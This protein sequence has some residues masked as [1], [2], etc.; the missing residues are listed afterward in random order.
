MFQHSFMKDNF[1]MVDDLSLLRVLAAVRDLGTVTEAGAVL[2][3]S[4]SAVSQQLKRLGRR[5]E[6]PVTVRSGRRVTLTPIAHD[7]LERATPLLDQLEEVLRNLPP[8]SG[9]I[10]GK[11]RVAA[12]TTAIR[13]GVPSALAHLR[14][15]HPRLAFEL[16]EL[17]PDDAYRAVASGRV[18]LAVVHHWEG[19]EP[20]THS[21]ITTR[22]VGRDVAD[23]IARKDDFP[24][25]LGSQPLE[26]LS[27]HDWVSTGRGTLC[28]SWLVS[29]FAEAGRAPQITAQLSDFTLHLDFVRAGLGLALIPRLGR[30][31]LPEDLAVLKLAHPPARM[32]AI[33]TRHVQRHDRAIEATSDQLHTVLNDHQE[34]LSHR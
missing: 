21:S 27:A 29:M 19:Q 28:H 11:V 15:L 13:A 10:S 17:D 20:L 32:V 16:I 4:P 12:F 22:R 1:I 5:L 33:A 24:T 8:A 18:D 31:P 30:S 23:V 2:G 6:A 26:A 14:A 25:H 7:L 3:L 9:S 34:S